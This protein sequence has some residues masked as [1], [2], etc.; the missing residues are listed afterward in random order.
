MAGAVTSGPGGAA[1]RDYSGA[2]KAYIVVLLTALYTTN[3]A[4]R[5]LISAVIG[6]IKADF[7]LNDGQMGMLG[8]IAFAIFYTTFGIPI[9]ILA[10][11]TSR[12]KI[13]AVAAAMW[14]GFTM[15]CGLTTN[16]WQLLLARIGVGI[17]EAGGSP[18]A[19]SIIS[20]LYE[21]KQRATA[22][23]VY[24]TGVPFGVALALFVGAPIA[25]AHGWQA[26]FIWL[27]V[28]GLVLSAL[29]L[30]TVREPRRGMSERRTESAEA[31][32]TLSV[33]HI[34]KFMLS[35]P[36]MRHVLTGAT[37]VTLV[38][39]AGVMW[40]LEFLIRSHGLGRVEASYYLG[41]VAIIAGVL[42]TFLGG[43]LSDW[44]GKRDPRWNSW[45]VALLFLIGLPPA[46]LAFSTQSFATL[47]W[48]L[49]IPVFVSGA[50]LAP[51]FA[52]TQNLVGIRMRA[53]ASALLLFAI[54]LIGM[55]VGPWLA[56]VLS[57]YFSA[58]YGVHALRHALFVLAFLNI[59]GIV[60]YFLAGRSLIAGYERAARS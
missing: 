48:L 30:L 46:L 4:D 23:A 8:G 57:D 44:L 21:P 28:P 39:Y 52:M 12:T 56:G 55:G 31:A 36:A 58:D 45:I 47:Q 22:L 32:Q 27:G 35:Q 9:A 17:G 38:G 29:L 60:H 25:V 41:V 18:P 49:P 50:Y 42:G 10:D 16:F 26:A 43:A 53:M 5:Q 40:N 2:Y 54:N 1:S 13:M 20:D 3:Y 37:I 15:L 59:W 14:S 6:L 34:L 51:T 11:R 19:H 33:W 7:G 24:A